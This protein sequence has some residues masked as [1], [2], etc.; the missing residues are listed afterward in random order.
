MATRR[1]TVVDM[2]VR[3]VSDV[4]DAVVAPLGLRVRRSGDT[5]SIER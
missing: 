2:P 3:S 1:V 4:L 5:F